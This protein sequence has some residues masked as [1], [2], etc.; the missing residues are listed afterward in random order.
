MLVPHRDRL[1]VRRG[2][3]RPVAREQRRPRADSRGIG[4]G[5]RGG[6]F[7]RGIRTERGVGRR[8]SRIES[9]GAIGPTVAGVSF[10]GG[11]RRVLGV[12][13]GRI[14]GPLGR[15]SIRQG[16]TGGAPASRRREARGGASRILDRGGEPRAQRED[17]WPHS[18]PS[19][20]APM[21]RGGSFCAIACARRAGEVFDE[22]TPRGPMGGAA[23]LGE[24]PGRIGASA[25]VDLPSDRDAYSAS[26]WG[27]KK[28]PPHAE[29]VRR[30]GYSPLFRTPSTNLFS[31][32]CL[33]IW[34]RSSVRAR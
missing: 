32:R 7:V 13:A 27:R 9:G 2:E 25:R 34:K 11:P 10:G 19:C 26:C 5:V 20:H 22:R 30:D 3:R 8:R 15:G 6:V 29:R 14:E 16:S 28:P 4:A 31:I 21:E 33:V 12:R 23:Q 18:R 24:S 17:P 1:E